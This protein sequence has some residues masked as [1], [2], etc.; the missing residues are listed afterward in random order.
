MSVLRK[1]ERGH[2]IKYNRTETPTPI[3]ILSG[4][5][6]AWALTDGGREP[7]TW[8]EQASLAFHSA[9]VLQWPAGVSVETAKNR[10]W[11]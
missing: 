10:N 11:L 6:R 2:I 1:A 5:G 4:W 3:Q 8:M 9:L 7:R